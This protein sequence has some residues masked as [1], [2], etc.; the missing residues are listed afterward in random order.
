MNILAVFL[1][2]F[3]V[4]LILTVIAFIKEFKNKKQ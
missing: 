4:T 2:M 1:T 3:I